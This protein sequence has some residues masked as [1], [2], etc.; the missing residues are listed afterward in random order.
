M[1]EAEKRVRD[2]Q[3][4]DYTPPVLAEPRGGPIPPWRPAPGDSP[5][6][7]Q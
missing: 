6:G 2:R 3:A 5:F 4:G 1:T 7:E